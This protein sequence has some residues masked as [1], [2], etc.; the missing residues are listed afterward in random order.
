MRESCP[1]HTRIPPK[2]RTV[3]MYVLY[4]ID[5][6]YVHTYI[7]TFVLQCIPITAVPG[8]FCRWDSAFSCR[9]VRSLQACS[10]MVSFRLGSKGRVHGGSIESSIIRGGASRSTVRFEA[11]AVL[12]LYTPYI[13]YMLVLRTVCTYVVYGVCTVHMYIPTDYRCTDYK[14]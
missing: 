10:Y 14:V 13:Q 3:H 12:A 8:G 6:M 4:C 7:H 2:G 9:L 5:C 1:S 11:R